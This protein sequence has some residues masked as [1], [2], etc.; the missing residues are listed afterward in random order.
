MLRPDY[1]GAVV[2]SS[3]LHHWPCHAV[4]HEAEPCKTD[5]HRVTVQEEIKFHYPSPSGKGWKGADVPG[6]QAPARDQ[7][8]WDLTGGSTVTQGKLPSSR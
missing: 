5:L 1:W 7:L 2:L 6:Q 8:R 3:R 4:H